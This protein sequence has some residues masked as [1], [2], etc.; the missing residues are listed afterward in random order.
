MS[1]ADKHIFSR[2]DLERLW[3]LRWQARLDRIWFA[4][5]VLGYPDLNQKVHGPIDKYL[6]TFPKPEREVARE[7]DKILDSG[8]LAYTPWVDPY[9]LEGS[10]RALILDHRSSMKT[11][12]NTIV[13]TL[14]WIINFPHMCFATI[15]S[16]GDK[17]AD[18]IKNSLEWHFKF[19]RNFRELFPELCP[20]TRIND[21]G[22]ADSF[23]VCGRE[24]IMHRLKKPPRPEPTVRSLSLDKTGTGYHFDVIKCSDIVEPTNVRTPGERDQ[25]K[26][27]VGLLPKLLVVPEGWLYLEGTFYHPADLYSDLVKDWRAKTPETRNWDIFIRSAFQRKFPTKLSDGRVLTEATFTPDDLDAKE[28]KKDKDGHEIPMWP[29]RFTW[30]ALDRIRRDPVEGGINFAAQY[31]LDLSADDSGEKPFA[32]P[33][34]FVSREAFSKIPK[35]YRITTIDLADTTGVRSNHSVITT[36]AFDRMGRCYV[37]DI[38]R[39][40]FQPAQVVDLMFEVNEKFRPIKIFFEETNFVN[41][42]RPTIERKSALTNVYPP[43]HFHHR[44]GKGNDKV[45]RIIRSLQPPFTNGDLMFVDPINVASEFESKVIRQALENEFSECTVASTGNSDDILDTLADL[46]LCRD[47]FGP[48]GLR[49]GV[50]V[51]EAEA[52]AQLQLEQF[53]EAQRKMTF[54]DADRF[55]PDGFA[56]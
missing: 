2:T 30:K 1:R 54:G 24:G 47:Y 41:G 26:N 35:E 9:K 20:T 55:T 25:V 46:F 31:L 52:R 48:E 3:N 33:P 5:E 19:N 6:M 21:W 29:E 13:D 16:T 4:N 11:H 43:F 15:F 53:R 7:S 23:T 38:R 44:Q 37:E 14:F 18:V 45:T 51:Q 42:L 17:A 22:T 34:K 8:R 10:R 12:Y 39:G 36:A 49:G 32:T 50:L 40:K 27:R 28:W 56:W